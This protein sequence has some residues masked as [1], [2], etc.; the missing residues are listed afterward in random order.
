MTSVQL[1]CIWALPVLFAITVHEAA[2]GWVAD[3]LGDHT[4]KMLGRVTLNPLKHIDWIGTVLVPIVLLLSTGFVFGWAKPVPLNWRNLKHYRRDSAWVA[5]A[6]PSVN[7]V[8]AFLWAIVAKAGM[9]LASLGS[10]ALFLMAV[11]KAGIAINL[12][13]GFLNLI[14]IPP[15]DGSRVVSSLLPP[16]IAMYYGKI[17]P[18]GFMILLLLLITGVL[19]SILV[20]PYTLATE[21]IYSAFALKN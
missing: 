6:G 4:A 17:E 19:M 18:F 16:R 8:M 2:H 14:P 21:W 11:G 1:L 10:P 20:P 12:M 15:L 3:R 13:L 5:A 9:L 7:I